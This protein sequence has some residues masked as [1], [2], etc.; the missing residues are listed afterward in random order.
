MLLFFAS[1]DSEVSAGTNE[2]KGTGR[3]QFALHTYKLSP[4]V[5]K[6]LNLGVVGI[7][8]R[9]QILF[10]MNLQP[11]QIVRIRIYDNRDDFRTNMQA[12]SPL[13]KGIGYYS[14]KKDEIVIWRGESQAAMVGLIFH[15]MGH[16]ILSRSVRRAPVWLNEGLAEYVA[17]SYMKET[18]W[19]VAQQRH[20]L[21]Q[22]GDALNSGEAPPLD[23]LLR[24]SYDDFHGPDEAKLYSLSWSLVWFLDRMAVS[25]GHVLKPLVFTL[26]NGTKAERNS[27]DFLN[28][29]YPGGLKQLEKDWHSSIKA[30]QLSLGRSKHT[31]VN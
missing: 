18:P 21:K 13:L 31:T 24:L 19:A 17:C 28:R 3:C 25:N 2:F 1:L 26:R 9:Y 10:G 27:S 23:S 6:V 5:E 22:C 20:R 15:E 7:T 30:S 11:K 4:E 29:T 8:Q 16:W 14:P 12:D